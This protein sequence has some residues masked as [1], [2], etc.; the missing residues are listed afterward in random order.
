MSAILAAPD[1]VTGTP[2]W[3]TLAAIVGAVLGFAMV[4]FGFPIRLKHG[5]KGNA[6]VFFAGAVI[7]GLS[8]M[9]LAQT[10]NR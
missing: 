9:I 4:W 3:V 1:I 6:K 7:T 2:A 10:F 8:L 5:T